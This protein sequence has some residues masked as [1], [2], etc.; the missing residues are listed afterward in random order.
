M[1]DDKQRIYVF[2]GMIASG[3]STLASG[4]AEKLGI[5][6]FNSDVVRKRLAGLAPSSRSAEGF[7]SGIYSPAFSRR[8][9]NALLAA[10]AETLRAGNSVILD[11]SYGKKEERDRLRQLAASFGASAR[12]ILCRCPEEETRRRLAIRAND[13]GAVSDGRWEIY[14]RQKELFELPEELA[15]EELIVI[16]TTEAPQELV[17]R[18]EVLGGF[19]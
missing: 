3:K 12:F 15:G 11:A 2:F 14:Q 8:T 10:A 9:Y 16:D 18:L 19:R 6:S 5:S 13:P 7:E 17:K 4:L 1:S